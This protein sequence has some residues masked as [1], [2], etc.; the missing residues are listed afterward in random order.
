MTVKGTDFKNRGAIGVVSVIPLAGYVRPLF[1]DLTVAALNLVG[2]EPQLKSFIGI[3][4]NGADTGFAEV[5]TVVPCTGSGF[6]IA[7]AIVERAGK[8]SS[9]RVQ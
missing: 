9:E 2:I 5:D 6:T 8:F 7:D 1:D 4:L 3:R